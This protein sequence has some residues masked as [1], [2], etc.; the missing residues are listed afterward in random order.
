MFFS[1]SVCAVVGVCAEFSRPVE[2]AVRAR[3]TRG[4]ALRQ[5]DAVGGYSSRHVV[6][7]LTRD[8]QRQ[9]FARRKALGRSAKAAT[10][11]TTLADATPW[12]SRKVRAQARRWGATR[13]APL[14]DW[15]PNNPKVFARYGLDCVYILHVPQG[16]NTSLAAR[17]LCNNCNEIA[18]ASADSMGKV[19]DTI[20]DDPKFS[21]L[22]GMHNTGQ[23]GGLKDADIDAPGAWD[24]HTG[25]V[26]TVTIAIIDSGIDI[27]PDLTHM[28]PGRNTDNVFV[29]T[30]DDCMHG[31]HVAGTAAATGNNG[32]GVAGVTWGANIM[33]VRVTDAIFV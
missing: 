23:T 26:G 21:L 11:A 14:I 8:A 10:T 33:P 17:S 9:A 30:G 15:E 20:P 13:I 32:I 29:G 7:R 27:H 5:P 24:I 16:T 4:V 1:L 28:V 22:Y 6:I 18:T 3:G 19:S 31:T 2:A 25:D 12:M